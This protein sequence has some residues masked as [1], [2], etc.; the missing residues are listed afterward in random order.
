ML[1]FSLRKIPSVVAGSNLANLNCADVEAALGYTTEER[2]TRHPPAAYTS[3][4]PRGAAAGS[5]K[6]NHFV[7]QLG[8]QAGARSPR[9][10]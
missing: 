8:F 7:Q 9:G 2:R 10:A 3:F 6:L 4:L 5:I 1:G